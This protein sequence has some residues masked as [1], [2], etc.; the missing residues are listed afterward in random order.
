MDPGNWATDLAG[1]SGFGYSLLFVVLVASVFGMVLQYLS[2]KLGIA[3]GRDLAQLCRESFPRS[4]SVFLW[5]MAEVM[6]IACDL[7]EVIGTAI[8]LNLLFK[9]PLIVGVIVTVAD[10]LVLLALQ[11]KGFRYLEAFIIT[12][13]ATVLGCFALELYFSQPNMAALVQGL[14]PP[15][16]LFTRNDMLYIALGI[17][18]ATV[19]PHNLYLH[20]AVVQTR[21]FGQNKEAKREALKFAT[22]DSTTAL[23]LA[24]FVNAAILIVAAAAFFTTRHTGV[25]QISSAYQLLTP[26]LGAG[27][28]STVFAIALLASG[29]NSTITGTMAGQVIMQGFVKLQIKPW[30]VRLMTRGLAIIPAIAILLVDGGTGLGRLLILSQVVLSVQLPFAILPLLYFTNRKQT[31][32]ELVNSVGMKLAAGGISVIVVGL[33]VWLISQAFA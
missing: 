2:V 20:S 14:L 33:N 27:L 23:A 24:F 5:L 4:L 18:G 17:V 28:A 8:A 11:N 12:L 25:Q 29:Q 26:L 31:M 3:T 30:L 1:G 9:L 19:M 22:I 10:V 13:L 15:A 16:Q 6:I 7:A 32:G 21:A